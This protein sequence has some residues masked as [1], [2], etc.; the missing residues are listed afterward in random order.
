MHRIRPDLRPLPLASSGS[1][2][3]PA[4]QLHA[5]STSTRAHSTTTTTITFTPNPTAAPVEGALTSAASVAAKKLGGSRARSPGVKAAIATPLAIFALLVL[6]CAGYLVW[7]R[8]RKSAGGEGAESFDTLAEGASG[9][10]AVEEA[11]ERGE[12]G[13]KEEDVQDERA[14]KLP[15]LEFE[16]KG[17]WKWEINGLQ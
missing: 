9:G 14:P 1:P 2:L 17:G 5:G 6:V 4:L 8:R 3:L 11:V 12:A 15:E 13:G 16:K 7:R 10:G